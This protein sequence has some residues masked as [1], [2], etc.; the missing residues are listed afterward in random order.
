MTFLGYEA[1]CTVRAD[2]LREVVQCL[3]LG[4]PVQRTAQLLFY[5]ELNTKLIHG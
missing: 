3:S 4:V 2:G 1:M 5:T